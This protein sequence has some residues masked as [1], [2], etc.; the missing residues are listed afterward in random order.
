MNYPKLNRG[1]KGEDVKRLQTFL[2]RV[3]AMLIADGDFGIGTKRGVQYAQDIA[4]L[5]ST[6]TVDDELWS[7]LESKPEPFPS[8]A[9]NGIAFIALEE[10]GGLAYYH[11]V[12]R[13]PHYPGAESGVTI[14][15]GYDLRFNT[16]AN[17]RELWSAHLSSENLDE[18]SKD[19]GKPG[20]EERAKELK[21]LGIEIPFKSA[22]LVFIKHTLPRFYSDTESI[23]PSLGKLP[24]LCRCVL[25]SIVFNRGPSLNGSSRRE[26][27]M[28]Q[29]ILDKADKPE[30]QVQERKMILADVE[31]QILLMMR[32]WKPSSGLC[33]RR[34]SEANLWRIG[35]EDLQA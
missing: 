25:V 35:L 19:I 10:T 6:G 33:K 18:L 20:S 13:W 31:E 16:E 29:D 34:Q 5:P 23:Y 12:S 14:G 21:Q 7:W 24:S 30:L 32:L 15:V 8:L 27:L 26:M 1:D 17:Y 2:N 11:D 4:N 9:T 22:W 3:G 28:I